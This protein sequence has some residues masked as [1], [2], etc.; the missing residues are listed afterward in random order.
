MSL[1]FKKK[2]VQRDA[3]TNK[4]ENHAP[5]NRTCHPMFIIFQI[6]TPEFCSLHM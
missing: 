1:N 3:D 2:R 5:V 4:T 6:L